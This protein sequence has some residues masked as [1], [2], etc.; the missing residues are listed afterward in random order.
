MSLEDCR[1]S[2]KAQRT[3]EVSF[4]ISRSIQNA[5]RTYVRIHITIIMASHMFGPELKNMINNEYGPN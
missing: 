1:D 3:S 4:N 2:P 5:R